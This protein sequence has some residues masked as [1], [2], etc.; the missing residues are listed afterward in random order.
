MKGLEM[1]TYK[2]QLQSAIAGAN[3]IRQDS[4]AKR[5]HQKVDIQRNS[6]KA[7]IAG[8]IQSMERRM[9]EY[10]QSQKQEC[11]QYIDDARDAVI[12]R[13]SRRTQTK[14]SDAAMQSL[15]LFKLRGGKVPDT[16]LTAMLDTHGGSYGYASAVSSL[17]PED[18]EFSH[19]RLDAAR[20]YDECIDMVYKSAKDAKDLVVSSL[21]SNNP[22]AASWFG[23]FDELLS[24]D[25][26][27]DEIIAEVE[28]FY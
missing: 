24:F 12:Q 22:T 25:D 21:N 13:L 2:E 17:L 5:E 6:Q 3:S 4:L 27:I 1:T 18:S 26:P 11:F 14:L 15:E 28:K 8:D 20:R 9:D 10:V 16:E 23:F 7:Q 19:P